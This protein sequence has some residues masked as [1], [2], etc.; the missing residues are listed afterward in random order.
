MRSEHDKEAFICA[1]TRVEPVPLAPEISIWAAS[2]VT[3]LWTATQATLDLHDLE[4]PFWAFAWAGGQA[5]ARFVLDEPTSVRGR[6]ALDFASG[7]AL[8]GIAACLSGAARVVASDIDPFAC[9]AA[10]LNA[11][12]A[13]VTLEPEGKDRVGDPLDGFDVILAGDVF[14]DQGAAARFDPW[15]RALD[16]DGK[17]VLVGD[18]GRAYFPKGLLPVRTYQVPVPFDLESAETKPATVYRYPRTEIPSAP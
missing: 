7:S 12:L 1:Q 17:L 16:A 15:F 5:L 13:G 18:P 2:L 9:T 4:P 10:R 8:V 14:Y 3:P 6:T 11:A